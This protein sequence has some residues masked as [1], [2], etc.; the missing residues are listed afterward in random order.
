MILPP[1]VKFLN[2]H[3]R[4]YFNVI[5]ARAKMKFRFFNGNVKCCIYILTYFHISMEIV[6]KTAPQATFLHSLMIY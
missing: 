5:M 4:E 1:N 3:E 2:N 6:D